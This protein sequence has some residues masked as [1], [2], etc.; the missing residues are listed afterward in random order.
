MTKLGEGAMPELVVSDTV[1]AVATV[2]IDRPPFNAFDTAL[3]IEL[4]EVVRAISDDEGVRAVVITGGATAFAAG[5]D[6]K[7]LSVMEYEQISVWNRALQRVFNDIAALPMPVIAAVNGV[8]LGGG[9]ELAL[10]ADFRVLADDAVLALPEVQLGIVPGAGGMQRL[11]RLVGV[12]KAKEILMSGRRLD[13]REALSIGVAEHVVAA[14]DVVTHAQALA[15]QF[16]AGPRFALQ[17]IKESIDLGAD[18]PL[19]TGLAMDKNLLAGLFATDDRK[20]GI[21]SF[22]DHGLGKA[23]FGTTP[24]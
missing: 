1:D 9:M 8:A 11:R 24:E 21:N 14:A 12:S 6:L 2:R 17:A 20:V 23:R 5:A 15:S 7:A 13:A 18:S 10:A 19:A 4:G 16:A 22:F 3:R